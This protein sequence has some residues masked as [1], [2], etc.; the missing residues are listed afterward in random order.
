MQLR[1]LRRSPDQASKLFAIMPLAILDARRGKIRD[2]VEEDFPFLPAGCT[3]DLDRQS[4]EIILA[5]LKSAVRRSRW[6][7]LVDDLKREVSLLK[8]GAPAQRHADR[9]RFQH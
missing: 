5:N 1:R 8:H 6:A 4:R 2:Q 7:T 9:Q 3:V